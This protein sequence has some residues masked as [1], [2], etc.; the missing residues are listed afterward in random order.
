MSDP[1]VAP[2]YPTLPQEL[3]DLIIDIVALGSC[4]ESQYDSDNCL[5]DLKTCA[6]VSRGWRRQTARHLF[7][8]L[9]L[10]SLTF[11]KVDWFEGNREPK[12]D[13][14]QFPELTTQALT[15]LQQVVQPGGILSQ[16]STILPFVQELTLDF[17]NL[18][19]F[20]EAVRPLLE[21]VSFV[22]N[23]LQ[24]IIFDH[25]IA[26][27]SFLSY[28]SPLL[29]SNNDTIKQISVLDVTMPSYGPA[30]RT[31]P[32]LRTAIFFNYFPPLPNLEHLFFRRI[33]SNNCPRTD[34]TAMA[35]L[36]PR[37]RPRIVTIDIGDKLSA[38]V[39]ERR[40]FHPGMVCFDL[41]G[42]EELRLI[43]YNYSW[44]FHKPVL[45]LC[46]LRRLT[47]RVLQSQ[48]ITKTFYSP[49]GDNIH[50]D[51]EDLPS[52]APNLTHIQAYIELDYHRAEQFV[53]GLPYLKALR[54]LQ[55]LEI[56]AKAEVTTPHPD[57]PV[58]SGHSSS[59]WDLIKTRLVS[60]DE[61]LDN[62]TQCTI[63]NTLGKIK[64][65]VKVK[66][67]SFWEA[68]SF[69]DSC[70]TRI[71][72]KF[73]AQAPNSLDH[74]AKLVDSRILE[75]SIFSLTILVSPIELTRAEKEAAQLRQ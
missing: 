52:Y 38:A 14:N 17:W 31:W 28:L 64:V 71:R 74:L 30:R 48:R 66:G 18:A 13:P 51:V 47:V 5:S 65:V 56:Q 59:S 1:L 16:N 35:P 27:D 36:L 61:S 49:D 37:P 19:D 9:T 46:T 54:F 68:K 75:A 57:S 72:I 69:V 29:L 11:T 43:H 39:Q 26:T 63:S 21:Q 22:P 42:M 40:L 62:L 34:S 23:Q 4:D 32:R 25:V 3:A 7:K 50:R 20:F 55:V 6:L 24:G 15:R 10:P 2:S 58:S 67:A 12:P 41:S 33:D 8:C 45:T 70:F 73:E 44:D 53:L 60:L